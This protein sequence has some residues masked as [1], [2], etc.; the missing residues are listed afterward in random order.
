MNFGD[1]CRR[2][3]K[4]DAEAFEVVYR[5]LKERADGYMNATAGSQEEV[6]WGGRLAGRVDVMADSITYYAPSTD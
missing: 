5:Y 1:A 4:A 2:L 3:H 6:V